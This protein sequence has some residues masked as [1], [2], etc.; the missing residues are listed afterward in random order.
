MIRPVRIGDAR[1]ISEIYNYYIEHTVITFEEVSLSPGDMENRIRDVSA[2]YPWFVYEEAG[3]LIGY[4]YVNKWKE[5]SAYRFAAEDSLYLKHGQEGRGLGGKL[6]ASL[7]EAVKKTGIH[8]IVAGITLPN[9][10]SVGLH[11]KWGFTQIACF[12]E[13]G[14]KLDQWLDVGY[15]ELLL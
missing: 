14:Y 4:A 9:E 5:R 11:E 15:W 8:S 3:E 12:K 7:L 1:A 2:N 13:I 6:M 10:R